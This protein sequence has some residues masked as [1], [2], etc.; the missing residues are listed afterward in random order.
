M[1]AQRSELSLEVLFHKLKQQVSEISSTQ[2]QE[3]CISKFDLLHKHLMT[4]QTIA[5][6]CTFCGGRQDLLCTNSNGH[7]FHV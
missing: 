1:A 3:C 2:K 7:F 4:Y 5:F 6:K